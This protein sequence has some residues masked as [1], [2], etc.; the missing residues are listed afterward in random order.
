MSKRKFK[1]VTKAHPNECSDC[2]GWG[3]PESTAPK[4]VTDTDG[5]LKTVALGS[6]CARCLGTGRLNTK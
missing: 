3:Y 5:K 4:M 1:R 6:G 2:E